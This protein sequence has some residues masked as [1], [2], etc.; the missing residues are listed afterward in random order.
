MT[1]SNPAFNIELIDELEDYERG[2]Q[3]KF[4]IYGT[5]RGQP[6]VLVN[7]DIRA[8]SLIFQC[9]WA[10]ACHGTLMKDENRV[11]LHPEAVA[12]TFTVCFSDGFITTAQRCY[13]YS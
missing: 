12:W 2:P 10:P 9:E 1:T 8:K 7:A 13:I 5:P 11:M 3:P 6:M 4:A